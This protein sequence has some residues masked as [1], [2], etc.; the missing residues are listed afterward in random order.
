VPIHP[1]L[2]KLGF[3]DDVMAMREAGH[4][5]L[6]PP[7]ELSEDRYTGNFSKWRGRYGRKHIT[8]DRAKC[9]HSFRHAFADALRDTECLESPSIR[10]VGHSMDGTFNRYGLGAQLKMLNAVMIKVEP[11]KALVL[12]REELRASLRQTWSG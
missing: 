5:R 1:I 3:L 7:L 12:R 9:F 4:G 2:E 6:F 11:P 10:L 8:A